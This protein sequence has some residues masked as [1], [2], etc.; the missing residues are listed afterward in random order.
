M[1]GLLRNTA[2]KYALYYLQLKDGHGAVGTYLARIDVI[3]TLQSWC[4]GQTEQSVEHL[5]TKCYHW[6]KER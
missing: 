4:C 3:E 2:K 6:Q 5:Y 1:N